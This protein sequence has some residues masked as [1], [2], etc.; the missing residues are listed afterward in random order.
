MCVNDCTFTINPQL[1]FGKS[2]ICWR[3]GNAFQLDHYSIKLKE[4]HCTRCHNKNTQVIY[5][6][7][8]TVEPVQTEVERRDG[9]ERRKD[10]ERRLND[11]EPEQ[12]KEIAEIRTD[13]IRDR[14]KV[15]YVTLDTEADSE[16][17]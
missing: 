17:L 8:P 9:E 12:I 5:S 13:N 16:F 15:K 2:T 7:S 10:P 1:A 11:L 6:N 4:P 3:C 14:M